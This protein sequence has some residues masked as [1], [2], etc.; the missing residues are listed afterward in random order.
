MAI[1]GEWVPQCN[2]Q[3]Y[4]ANQVAQE[5]ETIGYNNNTME[6]DTQEAVDFARNNPNSELHKI[7]EWDDKI[8]AEKYRNVQ[9]GN[10]L[11]WIKITKV[12]DNDP[13]KRE[14]TLIRYFVN[15][16]NHDGKY[17]KTE[18]VFSSA[19]DADRIL[20]QMRRD[21]KNFIE[22]Y[23]IYSDLNPNLPAAFT[24]LQNIMI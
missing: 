11:R 10:I 22:R 14:P 15:T 6:F 17:K 23:K 18:I 21:A 2:L 19:T 13:T 7:L 20:E 5:L 4:N 1:V 3:K 24:A 16:G 9:V 12:D 8:A